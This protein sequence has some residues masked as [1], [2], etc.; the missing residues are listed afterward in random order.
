MSSLP[1][2]SPLAE[3]RLPLNTSEIVITPVGSAGAAV[4]TV[5]VPIKG[6]IPNLCIEILGDQ[7]GTVTVS[8][9]KYGRTLATI[10]G[11]GKHIFVPQFAAT[12]SDKEPIDGVYAPHA[13]NN[14][15]LVIT[16]E[17]GDPIE[18]SILV[19]LDVVE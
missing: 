10:S 14:R 15:D 12:G 4:S 1:A 2:A 19:T 3:Y 11:A 7:S 17:D 9:P 5:H 8:D 18:E 6:I 16:V 13:M